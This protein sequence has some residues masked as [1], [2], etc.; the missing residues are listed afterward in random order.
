MKKIVLLAIF[1]TVGFC[2]TAQVQNSVALEDIIISPT[3]A[4]I[5]T[6]TVV[7]RN[8]GTNDLDSCKINCEVKVLDEEAIPIQV[9][10][11]IYYNVGG[12][13]SG[14]VDTF[15]VGK[16]IIPNADYEVCA[17]VSMPNGVEDSIINDDTLCVSFVGSVGVV[18]ISYVYEVTSYEIFDVL[19][20]N[21]TA[22]SRGTQCRSNPLE[23]RHCGIDS[24]SPENMEMLK[25]VQ[26]DVSYLPV[27]IYIIRMQT[28]QGIITKKI[29]KL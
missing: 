8:T 28:N 10:M 29:I 2:A 24:Q 6:V 18:E 21:I 23:T 27:G 11:N 13:P 20:R 19:G 16:F 26:H 9:I 3:N 4:E 1:T 25:Q 17:W 14:V 7:I 22:S 12:L 15:T 5:N